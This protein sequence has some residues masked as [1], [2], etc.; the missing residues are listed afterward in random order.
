MALKKSFL[1]ACALAACLVLRSGYGQVSDVA[2]KVEFVA[3]SVSIAGQDGAKRPVAV[4]ASLKAGDTIET[5]AN[6]ELHAAMADGGLI[7]VRPGSTFR[8]DAF[9]ANGRDDDQSA[10]SV[11][12]GAVRAVTGWISKIRP[13]A[14]TVQ[15]PTVTIGVRG[16]DHEIVVIP[17]GEARPGE[18][19]GTHSRVNAGVVVM[20]QGARELEIP[21][22][23]AAVA[24]FDGTGPRLHAGVPDFLARRRTANET[25]VDEHSREIGRHI[26]DRLRERGLLRPGE[27]AQKFIE[28]RRDEVERA[29]AGRAEK[30]ERRN[31]R[32]HR[33]RPRR[34]H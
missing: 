33:T 10:F 20:R 5:A 22:G 18:Q 8:I 12:R 31:E 29:R 3:G 19:A 2:A 21:S 4:G 16:T 13:R 34:Q 24:P 27:N 15:T 25:R 1:Y 17:P 9:S 6:G 7:A 32:E 30:E 28:R 23:R 11:V 26:E 14:Y